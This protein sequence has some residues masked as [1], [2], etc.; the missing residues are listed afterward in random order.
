MNCY[1]RKKK[2][3]CNE[4]KEIYLHQMSHNE[5]YT[6]YLWGD[7][8]IYILYASNYNLRRHME[9][10]ENQFYEYCKDTE[11]VSID[12]QIFEEVGNMVNHNIELDRVI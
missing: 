3:L 8:D 9:E 7:N 1:W 12:T 4:D 11:K 6:F 10:S 5:Q 2:I